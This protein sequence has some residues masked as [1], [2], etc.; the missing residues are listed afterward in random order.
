MTKLDVVALAAL[1]ATFLLIYSISSQAEK[2]V[3]RK[4]LIEVVETT[5]LE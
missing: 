4:A 5:I 3:E 2:A 1:A